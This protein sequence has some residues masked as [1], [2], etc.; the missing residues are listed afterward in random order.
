MYS[1]R[2]R[3][4]YVH[5]IRHVVSFELVARKHIEYIRKL[6]LAD[7]VEVDEDAFPEAEIDLSIP[8]VV[9][10]LFYIALKYS[11]KL[12]HIAEHGCKVI[13]I[14]VADSDA[15]SKTA[16]NIANMCSA[17]IVPSNFSR[18][19]YIKSGVKTPVHVVPHGV[20]L[21]WYTTPNV[22]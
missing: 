20:D 13:G 17:V 22:L 8:L 16:V 11:S 9:H 6:R 7:V 5:P 10:P 12:M 1:L 18:E 15:L 2:V 4:T 3:F 14:D 19:V 21:E